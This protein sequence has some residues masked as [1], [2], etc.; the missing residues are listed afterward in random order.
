MSRFYILLWLFWSLRLT[1]N[2]ILMACLISAF[3]TLGIYV[4]QGSLE[5]NQSVYEALFLVFKFWFVLSWSLTLLLSLFRELK[6]IFNRCINGYRLTLLSCPSE[7]KQEK[8]KEIGY[9][10]LVK[11][12][13]KWFMLIIWL[14]GA[15]MILVV[16]FTKLF[17]S[18][19][20][21]FDWFNIYTL[22][23]FVL[24]GGYFSF[25]ILSMRCKKVK[26]ERC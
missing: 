25:M 22:Y 14:V 9:G 5:L 7:G 20:A 26:I 10:D 16:A 15:Q 12:W 17:T 1:L 3:I 23:G 18:G 2:S 24:V 21:I 13:R 19:S 4:N 6:P 11:V 8:I